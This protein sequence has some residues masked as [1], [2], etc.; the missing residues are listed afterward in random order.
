MTL[1]ELC[2][3]DQEKEKKLIRSAQKILCKDLQ[4]AKNKNQEML[5][6]A[7]FQYKHGER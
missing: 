5:K 7:S 4:K 6:K 1:K 3:D 2:S